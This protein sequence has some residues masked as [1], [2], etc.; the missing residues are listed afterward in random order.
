MQLDLLPNSN[1]KE[2]GIRDFTDDSKAKTR[3]SL[4]PGATDGLRSQ[5]IAR[6]L[7]IA[8][9]STSIRPLLAKMNGSSHSPRIEFFGTLSIT[10]GSQP[11]VRNS[12]NMALPRRNLW[13]NLSLGKIQCSSVAKSRSSKTISVPLWLV[14]AATSLAVRNLVALLVL[15]KVK[16]PSWVQGGV[17]SRSVKTNAKHHV[18]RPLL[19]TMDIKDCFPSITMHKVRGVFEELGFSGEALAV[20]TKLTTWEFQLPQGAPTSPAIAN[21]ALAK[22]DRRQIGL[23]KQH[24]LTYTRYVDDIP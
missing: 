9:M 16:F 3:N 20:I 19:S 12:V 22:I 10:V 18:R 15:A 8:P 6:E 24:G 13:K 7:R 5:L 14:A 4:K 17:A 1:V 2:S 11:A 23:A 21:L